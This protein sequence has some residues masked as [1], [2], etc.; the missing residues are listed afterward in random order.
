MKTAIVLGATGLVGKHLVQ[1]LTEDPHFEKVIAIT[2]RAVEYTSDKVVNAVIQF[3]E[4]EQYPHLFDGNVLFSCLG[5][6]IKQ[7]GSFQNQRKVDFDYQYQA[8]KIAAEN[9][10]AHYILVSSAGANKHSKTPYFQMKG[11][12]ED[13]ITRLPFPKISIIQPSL[14][15]GERSEMR[16]GETLASLFMPVICTLPQ[17]KK[18][19]PISGN[20]VAKKMVSVSLLQTSEKQTYQLDEVFE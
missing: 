20:E 15:V 10:V 13:A 5:T 16:I 14:L 19:R 9:G 2:R 3:D 12:L 8:A 1:Q 18:Y 11:E 17:L 6:T 7:A 4:M